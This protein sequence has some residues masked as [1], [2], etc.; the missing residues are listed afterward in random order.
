MKLSVA[1]LTF[2]VSISM[3]GTLLFRAN[4]SLALPM[5]TNRHSGSDA[6]AQSVMTENTI[7]EQTS[8]TY[9]IPINTTPT[10][11]AP[12]NAGQ[13]DTDQ[14]ISGDI[15]EQHSLPETRTENYRR[16]REELGI[17]RG[18]IPP[19]AKPDSFA[20]REGLRRCWYGND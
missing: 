20:Y 3:I 8:P 2:G 15:V 4:E 1:A 7:E 12:T 16:I 11:T 17:C 5:N 9:T 14:P 6:I 13:V 10:N 19:Y 18:F